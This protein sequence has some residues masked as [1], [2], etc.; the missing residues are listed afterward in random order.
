MGST[1]AGASVFESLYLRFIRCTFSDELGKELYGNF[2]GVPSISRNA[3]DQLI[4]GRISLWFDDI[5]TR[6]KTEK[7]EDMVVCAFTGAVADLSSKLGN[8][9]DQW[10][11]GKIHRLVL[12][13]PLSTVKVLDKV[14]NLNRGPFPVGGSFH[15]ISV[16]GYDN[17]RPFDSNHGSSHRNIFDLSN[18]DNSLT[19]IP[20]GNSG[21]PASRHYCDQTARY[22]NGEYHADYFSKDKVTANARYHMRF[23]VTP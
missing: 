8:N 20:T 4:D 16:Y 17:N 10:Q 21:I 14:F 6:N 19:I 9:P 5:T 12:E 7:F 23:L 2:L 1:S 13:H 11:W 15:T 22:V 3:T 18:W